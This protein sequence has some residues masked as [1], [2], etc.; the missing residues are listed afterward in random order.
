VF[1]PTIGRWLTQD[2]MAFEAGD[3]NLYRYVGNNSTDRIDPS[4]MFGVPTLILPLP[5]AVPVPPAP[6]VLGKP[7]GGLTLKP[8]PGGV[9]PGLTTGEFNKLFPG[10]GTPGVGT[11]QVQSVQEY[12]LLL[13]LLAY[14]AKDASTAGLVQRGDM[15]KIQW[16][17]MRLLEANKNNP[18]AFLWLLQTPLPNEAQVKAWIAQLGDRSY[19]VRENASKQLAQLLRDPK[20]APRVFWLLHMANQNTPDA[21]IRNRTKALLSICPFYT[22]P[23]KPDE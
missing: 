14:I 21:E 3:A 20:T 23:P 13:E 7:N 11:G 10:V 17:I 9:P 22:R 4:G 15:D 5:N 2:P 1:D 8:P 6:G 19:K 18:N 12:Q 16:T